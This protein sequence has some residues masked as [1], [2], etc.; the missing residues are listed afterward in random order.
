MA[1]I[2][3]EEN[4][5]DKLEKRT[6]SPASDSW[7]KLVDRLD[8]D[9]KK[10]KKSMYWW[11]SIA[12]SLLIMI[13]V[14]VQ[15]FNTEESEEVM[16]QMVEEKVLEEQLN[17]NK[18]NLKENKSIELVNEEDRVEDKIEDKK[19]DLSIIK[20]SEIINL[21]K[22]TRMKAGKS[23]RLA[24]QTN[25]KEEK[26]IHNQNIEIYK[27][28]QQPEIDDVLINEALATAMQDLKNERSGVSDREIDS[29]L[30]VASKEL[31]KENSLKETSK[32]VNADLLLQSVE[33]E[34]GQSFRGKVFEALKGSFETVKTAVVNRN[35]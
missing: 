8:E 11:L 23:L 6:L 32:T 5:K 22:I 17:T 10:S 35:N 4:I 13:A 7:S 20:E 30:K 25:L 31:F 34:M 18:Q 28:K 19:E 26:N 15:F 21:K 3:F 2:K 14:S 24:E 16:P 9:E 12:A 33:D 1:P 29:L 27:N